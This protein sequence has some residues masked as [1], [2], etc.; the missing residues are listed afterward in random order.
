MLMVRFG[1]IAAAGEDIT[2]DIDAEI[3]GA[4]GGRTGG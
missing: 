3:G 1:A 2:A 4:G